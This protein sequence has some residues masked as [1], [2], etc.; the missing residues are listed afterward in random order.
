VT[1]EQA[2]ALPFEA[3]LLNT[4]ATAVLVVPSA[5]SLI[6]YEVAQ[7]RRRLLAGVKVSYS[8]IFTTVDTEDTLTSRLSAAITSGIFASKLSNA[9]GIS[10]IGVSG[11]SEKKSSRS[12]SSSSSEPSGTINALDNAIHHTPLLASLD[13]YIDLD[14]HVRVPCYAMSLHHTAYPSSSRALVNSRMLLRMSINVNLIQ[15]HYPLTVVLTRMN[16]A[17]II[18]SILGGCILIACSLLVFKYFKARKEHEL[19]SSVSGPMAG[20]GGTSTSSP[21]VTGV[22]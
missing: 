9:T 7:N 16:I 22:I 3:S 19:V 14:C 21:G 15:Y 1:Y 6:N 4:V 18:G 5:V 11:Y 2:I 17:I 8:A 10:N 20:P 13:C 12:S